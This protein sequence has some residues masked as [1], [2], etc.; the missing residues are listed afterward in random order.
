MLLFPEVLLLEADCDE[1]VDFLVT[2]ELFDTTF[3]PED[4]DLLCMLFLTDV[5]TCPET[6]SAS[7]FIFYDNL[8]GTLMQYL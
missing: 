1:A 2:F 5:V 8:T 6:V 4:C 7:S 3:F